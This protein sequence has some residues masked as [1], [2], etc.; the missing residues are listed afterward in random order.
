MA[1]HKQSKPVNIAPYI[2]WPLVTI[3]L[4]FAGLFLYVYSKRSVARIVK[5]FSITERMISI[6]IKNAEMLANIKPAPNATLT[7]REEFYSQA[8]TRALTNLTDFLVVVQSA[9]DLGQDDITGEEIEQ[10]I[11]DI[12]EMSGANSLDEYLI[13]AEESEGEFRDQVRNQLIYEKMTYPIRDEVPEPPQGELESYFAVVRQQFVIPEAV[14]FDQI[15]VPD[16]K[17]HDKVIEELAKAKGKNFV[18]MA[19]KYSTDIAS[20][21]N[22]GKVIFMT[23][24]QLSGIPELANALFPPS[25]NFPAKLEVGIIQGVQTQKSGVYIVRLLRRHPSQQGELNGKVTVWN[26][27]KVD[28][29]SKEKG[30]YEQVEVEPSVVASWKEEKGNSAVTAYV[31]RLSDQYESFVYDR[32]KGNMPWAGLER[33]FAAI[34]GQNVFNRIMGFEATQQ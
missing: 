23:R 18:E 22:G 11:K 31:K 3:I 32:V 21:E 28:P 16:I 12:L 25:A 34:L 6:D 10:R 26:P 30:G 4:V 24:D 2:I 5:D 15:V 27:E 9:K 1:I 17:T 13:K 14:D 29:K 19:K 20:K 8:R 33:M 7:E